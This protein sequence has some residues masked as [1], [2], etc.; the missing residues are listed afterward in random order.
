MTER[1]PGEFTTL[2]TQAEA[3]EQVNKNLRYKQILDVMGH[4]PDGLTAKE[5]AVEMY[6]RG[7]IPTSER[8][9]TAPRLT[10][11]GRRGTVEP[12]GKKICSYTGKKVTVW[13]LCE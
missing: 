9:F 2:E 10:E 3:G 11:L 6:R 8:N 12:I 1:R 5:I 13:G 7:D 4:N